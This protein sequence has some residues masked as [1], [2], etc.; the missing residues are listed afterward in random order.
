MSIQWGS[1]IVAMSTDVEQK[2]VPVRKG[3]FIEGAVIT[4][5]CCGETGS[6]ASS[7][8]GETT[9]ASEQA[10]GCCGEQTSSKSTGC[11]G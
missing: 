6:G 5:G 8:C 1:I 2:D 9:A 10:S 3:G 11:C 7:C 4:S